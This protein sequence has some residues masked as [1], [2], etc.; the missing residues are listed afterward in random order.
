MWLPFGTRGLKDHLVPTACS[1][2]QRA[3][4]LGQVAEGATQAELEHPSGRGVHSVCVWAACAS[5]SPLG[6]KQP[7]ARCTPMLGCCE[8]WVPARGRAARRGRGRQRGRLGQAAGW[9][10]VEEEIPSPCR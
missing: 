3:Q 7:S 6:C 9:T 10:R 5:T 2:Q 4:A 1:G 8:Q